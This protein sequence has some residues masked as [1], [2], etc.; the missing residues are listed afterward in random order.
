MAIWRFIPLMKGRASRPIFAPGP[1]S[2]SRGATSRGREGA[3]AWDSPLP[4]PSWRPTE[5]PWEPPT[6]QEAVPRYGASFP[7]L[8]G[9]FRVRV[10]CGLLERPT[11]RAMRSPE[12]PE[13]ESTLSV[14]ETT[15]G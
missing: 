11:T 15:G 9:D 8:S 13:G 6:A 5:V 3:R 12:Q 1:L 7:A 4:P 2:A 10:V 14:D